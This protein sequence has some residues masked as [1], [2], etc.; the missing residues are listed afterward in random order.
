MSH[1]LI[2]HCY[3]NVPEKITRP[4]V[5][6][7]GSS[8]HLAVF[9][10]KHSRC[11]NSRPKHVKKRSYANFEIE[12]FLLDIY[13]SDINRRVTARKDIEEAAMEFHACFTEV[14]NVHAPIKVFQMRKNY[15]PYLGKET[16]L[17]IEKKNFLF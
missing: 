14:L 7:I 10:I 17:L 12:K 2:D 9:I 15:L 8:D 13:K 4:E 6:G 11:L 16:K 3:T 1:S 5:L